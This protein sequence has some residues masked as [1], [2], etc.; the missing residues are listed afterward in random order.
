MFFDD[1]NETKAFEAEQL[2]LESTI[3]HPIIASKLEQPLSYSRLYNLTEI[4]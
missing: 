3:L 2:S 1:I 4:V